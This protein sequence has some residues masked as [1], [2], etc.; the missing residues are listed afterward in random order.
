MSQQ[1]YN[2]GFSGRGY[3][4]TNRDWYNGDFDRWRSIKNSSNGHASKADEDELKFIIP[5]FLIIFGVPIFGGFFPNETTAVVGGVG[6]TA[7]AIFSDPIRNSRTKQITAGLI[8]GTATIV[9]AVSSHFLPDG[10]VPEF[11]WNHIGTFAGAAGVGLGALY[12]KSIGSF[13]KSTASET[14][15]SSTA[16]TDAVVPPT[17]TMDAAKVD[18]PSSPDAGP[19]G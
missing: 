8:G 4:P 1:D 6:I 17:R 14:T 3:Q 10:S 2:D 16:N 9:S 7:A 5:S 19:T 15:S 13:F 11:M 12:R 18:V